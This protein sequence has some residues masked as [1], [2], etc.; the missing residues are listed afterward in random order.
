M[1]AKINTYSFLNVQAAIVGPGGSFSLGSDA[2]AA[3]EGISF[4]AAT[5][6]GTMTTGAG[7]E[8]MHSLMAS[9]AS[10]AVVRL[11]K[12]SPVNAQLSAMLALQRTSATLYGQNTITLVNTVS[13]DVITCQQVGFAKQPDLA[14]A[15][16]GGT[17]EWEFNIG[18]M[19]PA[20][21]AGVQAAV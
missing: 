1:A 4:S 5:E 14:Y 21:G 20:L 13:G 8:V 19:D 10:K 6:L 2:G 7:G 17:V 16:E 9:K 18:I 3:D 12:T 15:K 11:L